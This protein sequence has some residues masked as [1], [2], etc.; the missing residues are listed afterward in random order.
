MFKFINPRVVD[1]AGPILRRIID[2]STS[3]SLYSNDRGETRYMRSMTVMFAPWNDTQPNIAE[4]GIGI[5]KTVSDHG[6]SILSTTPIKGDLAVAFMADR[7]ITDK[8]HC[9]HAQLK[10]CSELID[11]L[12]E[13]GFEIEIALPQSYN[14][15]VRR[16][17]D[18]VTEASEKQRQ[19]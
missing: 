1:E 9:F 8:K 7:N 5:S 2:R 14:K 16:F 10:W 4:F 15:H 17:L 3:S 6:I 19:G 18:S 11:G 12:Y 13:A